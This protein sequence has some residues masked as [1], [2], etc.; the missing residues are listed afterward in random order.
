MWYSLIILKLYYQ[1]IRYQ[2]CLEL[3]YFDFWDTIWD[4]NKMAMNIIL[5]LF[6]LI[7]PQ[8]SGLALQ[9]AR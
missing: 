5:M 1:Y 8:S 7:L 9:E 6:W 2:I 3:I 4:K